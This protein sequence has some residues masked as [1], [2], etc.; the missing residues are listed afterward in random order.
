VEAVC[1][2][3]RRAE[4]FA[5]AVSEWEVVVKSSTAMSAE[6]GRK[7]GTD[8]YSKWDNLE[9]TTTIEKQSIQPT[10][11]TLGSSVPEAEGELELKNYYTKED[12]KRL[13]NIDAT[14]EVWALDVLPLRFFSS[15]GMVSKRTGEMVAAR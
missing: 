5:P 7:W 14:N 12:V 9:E 2:R 13:S 8:T 3:T 11:F 15:S 10:T 4:G 1:G 6:K